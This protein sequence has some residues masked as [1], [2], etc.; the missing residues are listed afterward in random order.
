MPRD[1]R[2]VAAEE[3]WCF[4]VN[5]PHGISMDGDLYGVADEMLRVVCGN[6]QRAVRSPLRNTC[7]QLRAV[8]RL[9]LNWLRHR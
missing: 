4:S 3:K 2:Y 9:S 7:A 1:G 5:L 6:P 8:A